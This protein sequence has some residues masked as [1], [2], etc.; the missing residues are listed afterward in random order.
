MPTEDLGLESD[1]PDDPVEAQRKTLLAVAVS[2]I[3]DTM[4]NAPSHDTRLA[5]ADRVLNAF[6]KASPPPAPPG[7]TNVLVLDTGHFA[8]ALRGL[9]QTLALASKVEET[10]APRLVE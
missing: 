8:G 7:A 9:G 3:L 10:P 5:A 6:G 4:K 1:L 2:T